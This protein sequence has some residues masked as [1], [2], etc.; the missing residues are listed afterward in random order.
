MIIAGSTNFGVS[1]G[2]PKSKAASSRSFGI[3]K[4]FLQIVYSSLVVIYYIVQVVSVVSFIFKQGSSY[5]FSSL[6]NAWTT[7]IVQWYS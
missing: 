2:L 6:R 3:C 1:S 4:L 7:L 5:W